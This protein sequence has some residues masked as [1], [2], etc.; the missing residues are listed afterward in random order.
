MVKPSLGKVTPWCICQGSRFSFFTK[1]GGGEYN[2]KAKPI[3]VQREDPR[4]KMY[5][6]AQHIC[7]SFNQAPFYLK[8]LGASWGPHRAPDT[9]HVGFSKL[10][11]SHGEPSEFLQMSL[12]LQLSQGLGWDQMAHSK[13]NLTQKSFYRRST[14]LG[15][16][17]WDSFF[18]KQVEGLGISS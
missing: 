7:P 2:L 6:G 12:F 3:A 11:L 8:L 10:L 14:Q 4:I 15:F 16:E 9:E 1:A 5:V 18:R 13:K 17:P